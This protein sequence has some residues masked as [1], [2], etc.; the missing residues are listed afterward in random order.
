ME[1]RPARTIDMTSIVGFIGGVLL[2]VGGQLAW[3]HLSINLAKF[4]AALGVDASQLPG[5]LSGLLGNNGPVDGTAVTAGK[6]ALNAGVL[7]LIAAIPFVFGIPRK[8]RGVALVIAGLVGGGFAG[9]FAAS[10]KISALDKAGDVLGQLGLQVDFKSL[11]DTKIEIGVWLCVLGGAMA[12]VAGVLSLRPQP[13]A[14][15]GTESSGAIPPTP[16]TPPMVMPAAGP[17]TGSETGQT[18]RPDAPPS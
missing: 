11:F 2:V 4:S 17:E 16:P 18:A 1:V 6:I 3:A 10:P 9:Y 5:N 12:V 13:D 8:V 7:A 14:A 15:E